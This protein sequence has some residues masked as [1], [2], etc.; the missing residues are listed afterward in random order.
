M[1]SAVGIGVASMLVLTGV[2]LVGVLPAS[3]T[4]TFTTPG[5][6]VAG[7]PFSV[8]VTA[9]TNGGTVTLTSSCTLDGSSTD[10]ATANGSGSATFS[11]VQI[12]SAGSCTLTAHDA[13]S[14]TSFSSGSFAVTPGAP[15]KVVFTTAPA[16]VGAWGAALPTFKVSVEDAKGNVE[17]TG[18]TGATDP[19]A[20]T[21]SCPLNATPVTVAAANGVATFTNDVTI[22]SGTPC[23]LTATDTTTSAT[24]ASGSIAMASD[25]PAVLAFTTEPTGTPTAGVA[26]A[27]FAV[28]VEASN[29]GLSN[30]ADTISLSSSCK[31]AG[32]TT[33]LA[34]SGVATFSDLIIDSSGTCYLTATDSSRTLPTVSSSVV[35][36]L[37]STPTHLA[38]VTTPPTTVNGTGIA[39]STFEVAVEDVYGNIDSTVT[40]STDSIV[41]SSPCGL[42]GSTTGVA[43]AGAATFSNISFTGTGSCVL[44]ATDTS[45]TLTVATATTSVGEPQATL[46]LT[47]TS[48]YLDSPLA[49]GTKGG[50]GAGAV[51]YTVANGT[52]TGCAITSGALRA[53]TAGTCIVTATKAAASP[54]AAASTAATTIT[55]S[56]APKALHLAGILTIG[57][58]S[59]VTISGYNFS[60]RPRAISN[61]AG[62]TATVSRDTGKLLTLSITVKASATRPGVKTMT[63]IFAN[64]KRSS[65]KY[66]LH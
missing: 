61:V 24:V 53:T 15:T 48:G 45:R 43:S 41:L 62:F 23:T 47:A 60:G 37:P 20:I 32:V 29:G 8:T 19:I 17:T 31:L 16:S 3:A 14:S 1:G 44:T 36:V 9:A 39:L 34:S 5:A 12:D 56:S 2:S 55:I 4:P 7:T 25:T 38:F 33:A 6:Q 21:S 66:S 26:L 10:S 40:G 13:G 42:G 22:A 57:R 11:A 49:L 63:L 59:T 35:Q 64:G 65:F 46:S 50:S 58:K 51:T 18:N 28:S 54:Y 30:F 27:S 52:A